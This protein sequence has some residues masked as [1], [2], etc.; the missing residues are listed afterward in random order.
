MRRQYKKVIIRW[1][2]RTLPSEPWCRR[3]TLPP[4]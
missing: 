1:D 4:L 2:R 3:K